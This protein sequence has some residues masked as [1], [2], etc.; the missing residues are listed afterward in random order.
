M[1]L[2]ARVKILGAGK[3]LNRPDQTA[4]V[5]K[6][7]VVEFEGQLKF[8][9]VKV[10]I[11]KRELVVELMV[12]MESVVVKRRYLCRKGVMKTW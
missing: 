9:V 10:E 1:A 8:V 11:R 12:V 6:I 3:C 7:V 4:M 2:T 5:R